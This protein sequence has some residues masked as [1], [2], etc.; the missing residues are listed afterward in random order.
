MGVLLGVVEQVMRR[1]V[2][3]LERDVALPGLDVEDQEHVLADTCPS[4]L[5]IS[6]R[7]LL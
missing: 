1:T 5:E 6:Q 3:R 7:P 4:G 2:H